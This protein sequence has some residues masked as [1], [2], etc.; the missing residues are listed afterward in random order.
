MDASRSRHVG[1]MDASRSR[2]VL[3]PHRHRRSTSANAKDRSDTAAKPEIIQVCRTE[4]L[5]PTCSTPIFGQHTSV[6]SRDGPK[7][8]ALGTR[9][10]KMIL[11][12]QIFLTQRCT[13]TKR[14]FKITTKKVEDVTRFSDLFRI[15]SL[16]V[17]PTR[18]YSVVSE[19]LA[20]PTFIFRR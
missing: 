1:C 9:M 19:P 7:P 12:S 13:T 20:R 18:S 11:P 17:H 3:C 6:R 4:D 15:Y 8:L 2:R 10:A 16:F 5:T 14:A